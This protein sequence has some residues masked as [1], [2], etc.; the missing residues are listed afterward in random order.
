MEDDQICLN[1]EIEEQ[2]Y[3]NNTLSIQNK[4][5]LQIITEQNT[6]KNDDLNLSDS[7]EKSFSV[8]E[9]AG[10]VIELQLKDIEKEKLE[11]ENRLSEMK[12][13]FEE[14]HKESE[15]KFN[16]YVRSEKAL[17]NTINTLEV[18]LR[19]KTDELA[20]LNQ[21][22]LNLSN[23]QEELQNQLNNSNVE[24]NLLKH[25][26]EEQLKTENE[27]KIT[28]QNNKQT[29]DFLKQR[30]N[31]F[32]M[33]LNNTSKRLLEVMESENLLQHCE[34]NQK[35]TIQDL[36]KQ[37][38]ISKDE[39]SNLLNYQTIVDQEKIS[40]QNTF[41]KTLHDL[42]ISN[43]LKEQE[44]GI[45]LRH[46][47]TYEK[48]LNKTIF[49]LKE[50][51]NIK[52]TDNNVLKKTIKRLSNKHRQSDKLFLQTQ[53]NQQAHFD[54][55]KIKM[56]DDFK[57]VLNET[58][59]EYNAKIAVWEEKLRYTTETEKKLNLAI[60]DLNEQLTAKDK[61]LLNANQYIADFKQN[62]DLL[63][64]ENEITLN[65]T[66]KQK[67]EVE[68]TL[69]LKIDQL[70]K[71]LSIKNNN[72][73][74]LNHIINNYEE[75]LCFKQHELTVAH[76]TLLNLQLKL[77]DVNK[78]LCVLQQIQNEVCIMKKIEQESKEHLKMLEEQK[79]KLEQELLTKQKN[80]DNLNKTI[81][82]LNSQL[83]LKHQGI[84][85]LQSNKENLIEQ[86]KELKQEFETFKNEFN[87]TLRELED[88]FSELQYEL[89][90]NLKSSSETLRDMES[91]LE[92]RK[93][94]IETLEK[95]C[96]ENDT[97]FSTFT[98][99]LKGKQEYIN[100]L[101]ETIMSQ[102]KLIEPLKEDCLNLK[103]QYSKAQ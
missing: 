5:Y 6:F 19:T 11:L 3:L 30:I 71:L 99:D 22:L 102:T 47:N 92:I 36:N 73:I 65:N 37:L 63:K 101:N 78:D 28:L 26:N 69:T 76:D 20:L 88:S 91:Q 40:M 81:Q 68:K 59:I 41:Q 24:I 57:K 66:I 52:T 27:Y 13:N 23:N 38:L 51:L 82:A 16:S 74:S 17:K 90:V 18:Q 29:E 42:I 35:A 98:D 72:E 12:T 83:S 94:K 49:T 70:D 25:L 7:H 44:F 84:I 10:C 96:K 4:E 103:Q 34:E 61:A 62:I 45:L 64:T 56:K 55:E 9:N 95:N 32:E 86:L 46:L 87:T 80:E 58:Y 8:P 48:N 33:E 21:K 31:D 97:I 77:E 100:E 93:E 15:V 79:Q 89:S 60:N 50:Q 85:M 2:M 14:K 54:Y 43:V 39:I 67:T 1:H 53:N 75:Q